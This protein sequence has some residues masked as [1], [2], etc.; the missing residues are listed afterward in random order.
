MRV[1]APACLSAF[2]SASWTMRY[3]VRSMPAGSSTGLAHHA[4]LHA[5]SRGARP[6]G[7]LVQAGDAR[8]ARQGLALAAPHRR[9]TGGG[10]RRAPRGRCARSAPP[11][12]PPAPDCDR[13]SGAP[14]R[15]ARP[16]R[17][18]CARAR[19]AARARSGCARAAIARRSSA[20]RACVARSAFSASSRAS[21]VWLRI[22]RPATHGTIQKNVTGK[23]TSFGSKM[24]AIVVITTAAPAAPADRRLPPREVPSDR[25]R[26]AE[27]HQDRREQVRRLR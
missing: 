26:R 18:G 19:R 13:R 11:P 9:R 22:V 10:S 24:I 14:R 23:K 25:V 20:S 7:E 15:P 21:S 8:R 16:S 3:A 2:V 17:S 6:A 5:Q 4:E 12:R 1:A 27:Q